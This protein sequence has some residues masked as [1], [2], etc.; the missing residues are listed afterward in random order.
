M[1]GRVPATQR[2]R[3]TR[4]CLRVSRIR[5]SDPPS[6]SGTRL[7]PASAPDAIVS[8]ADKAK[9]V[10]GDL[11]LLSPM[12]RARCAES[13][14]C[15]PHGPFGIDALFKFLHACRSCARSGDELFSWLV[16]LG[17][18]SFFLEDAPLALWHT[19]REAP[20]PATQRASA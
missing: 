19:R 1:G 16:Y 18:L 4:R 15:S 9:I 2:A 12:T 10:L 14:R 7:L 3:P 20:D 5:G 13:D 8:R 6:V 17:C 11:V